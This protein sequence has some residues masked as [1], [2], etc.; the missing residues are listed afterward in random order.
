MAQKENSLHMGG[1]GIEVRHDQFLYPIHRIVTGCLVPKDNPSISHEIP[2]QQRQLRRQTIRDRFLHD[3]NDLSPRFDQRKVDA[4]RNESIPCVARR[5]FHDTILVV[6][7][8][9]CACVEVFSLGGV[10]HR[11]RFPRSGSDELSENGVARGV[12]AGGPGQADRR[13]RALDR[14]GQRHCMI[15]GALSDGA[16]HRKEQGNHGKRQCPES[17]G[18]GFPQGDCGGFHG[19]KD[20]P[21]CGQGNERSKFLQQTAN[22]C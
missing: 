1:I 8:D 10:Q 18:G 21:E 14:R 2:L 9:A 4:R 11:S 6:P 22:S 15:S 7:R 16:H 3:Q 12:R 20:G 19:W 13:R 5:R 17:A